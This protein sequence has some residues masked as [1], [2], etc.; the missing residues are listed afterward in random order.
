MD[1]YGFE[2]WRLHH[3][4]YSTDHVL[5]DHGNSKLLTEPLLPEAHQRDNFVLL[6][7]GGPR[8][9]PEAG[10]RS[11]ETY[12]SGIYYHSTLN[13]H[14]QHARLKTQYNYHASTRSSDYT[15]L[16]Y[17]GAGGFWAE[18]NRPSGGNYK[19]VWHGYN[20]AA[21]ITHRVS[22]ADCKNL[23]YTEHDSSNNHRYPKGYYR[24]HAFVLKI[25]S[26]TQCR[27]HPLLMAEQHRP[28]RL[29]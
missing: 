1:L 24:N 17:K 28:S 2:L 22:P 8:L 6:E 14:Q 18:R 19:R 9:E 13:T 21:T 15:S 27:A 3:Q 11:S 26:S 20:R 5:V 25:L 10:T 16:D 4:S 23:D 12:K 29:P 7:G